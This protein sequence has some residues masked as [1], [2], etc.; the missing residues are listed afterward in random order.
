MIMEGTDTCFAPVLDLE[1]APRHSHNR[2]RRAFTEVE[3]VIQPAPTPRFSKTPG[4][5]QC[6]PA[7]AGKDNFDALS[8]WGFSEE[9]IEELKAAGA[10]SDY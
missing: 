10:I 5:V 2:K 1:E 8:D 3:G 4:S 9:E 6:P 7:A